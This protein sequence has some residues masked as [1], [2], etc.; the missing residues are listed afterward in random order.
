MAKKKIIVDTSV[1][2]K[3]LSSDKEHYLDLA[4]KLL[5][6]ALNEKIE[7]IAPELSKYEVGNVLL[8]SK[9]LSFQQAVII[10][11]QFYTLPITFISESKELAKDTYNIASDFGVTYYDASFLS[12][13]KQQRAILITENIKHQGKAKDI[14][15]KSLKDF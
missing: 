2:I 4:N 6:D 9:K 14:V 8:F 12:L 5:E 15:V 7:L 1:I 11:E 10:L 13:A 3:W